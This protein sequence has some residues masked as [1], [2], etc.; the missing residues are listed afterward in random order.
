MC[1]PHAAAAT[2]SYTNIKEKHTKHVERVSQIEFE[3]GDPNFVDERTSTYKPKEKTS[4]LD[5][6][7]GS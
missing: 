5:S 1:I 6:L 7:F 3:K 4:F 2:K